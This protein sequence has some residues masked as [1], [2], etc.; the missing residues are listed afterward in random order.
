MTGEMVCTRKSDADSPNAVVNAF[1]TQ[2]NAVTSA[3]FTA[4]DAFQRE[5]VTPWGISADMAEECRT[6]PGGAAPFLARA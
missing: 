5:A 4:V 6:S 2:K 3:T 1:T